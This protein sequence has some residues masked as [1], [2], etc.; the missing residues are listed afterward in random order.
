MKGWQDEYQLKSSILRFDLRDTF[1]IHYLE[2][3]VLWWAL[4]ELIYFLEFLMKLVT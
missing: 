1:K 4:E 3:I 2:W